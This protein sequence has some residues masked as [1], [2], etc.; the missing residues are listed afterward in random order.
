MRA[1][2]FF[3]MEKRRILIVFWPTIVTMLVLIV[4]SVV[5]Y[6]PAQLQMDA[7]EDPYV[8][9]T[10]SPLQFI[11]SSFMSEFRL[12]NCTLNNQFRIGLVNEDQN[13]NTDGF[14]VLQ[15]IYDELAERYAE[16]EGNGFT[17]SQIN[18]KTEADLNE[19]VDKYDY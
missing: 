6:N 4:A 11:D 5:L 7:T 2:F 10:A 3:Q 16:D 19:Y 17:M 1:R 13:G 14:P 12:H 9:S 15:S 18:F 8:T